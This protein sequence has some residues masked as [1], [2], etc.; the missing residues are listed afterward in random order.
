M[1]RVLKVLDEILYKYEGIPPQGFDEGGLATPKRGLVDEPGSYAGKEGYGSG[2]LPPTQEARKKFKGKK[3]I[4]VPDPSYSDGRRRVMT[5][6]YKAFVEKLQAKPNPAEIRIK[7][8]YKIAKSKLPKGTFPSVEQI[9]EAVPGVK[10]SLDT[11]YSY[12]EKNKLK[13]S[14]P[15]GGT[16][17]SIIEAYEKVSDSGDRLITKNITNK[18]PKNIKTKWKTPELLK[19]YVGEILNQY[20]LPFEKSDLMHT[21]RSRTKAGK[22]TTAQA[23]IENIVDSDTLAKLKADIKKY[24]SGTI[25]G[26][27]QTMKISD[28]K[29]YFPEGTSDVVVSRQVNRLGNEMGLKF[30]KISKPEELEARK[31]KEQ[32][33]KVGDPKGITKKMKGTKE[34]PLHHMRAK[35]FVIEGQ[36]K[37]ISPSLDDL[38]YIDVVTNS[39]RLQNFERVRNNLANELLELKETKPE[40]WERRVKEINALAR[41][42]SNNIP[43][44]LRGLLYFETLDEAGNLKPIGGNPY[45]ALGKRQPGANIPFDSKK[46]KTSPADILSKMGCPDLAAGGRVGFQEGTT[47]FRKGVD[48]VNS[49]KIAKGTEAEN[50]GKFLKASGVTDVSK[51]RALAKWG[52][53]P[54]AAFVAGHSLFGMGMG[55]NLPESLKRASEYILP[56]DQ[57]LSADFDKVKRTLGNDAA[58][59]FKSAQIYKKNLDKLD[60]LKQSKDNALA[61]SGEGDFDYMTAGMTEEDINKYYDKHIKEQEEKIRMSSVSADDLIR[62]ERIGDEAYDISKADPSGMFED[63][64]L[65]KKFGIKGPNIGK[66]IQDMQVWGKENPPVEDESGLNIDLTPITKT[67]EQLN[68]NLL[69]NLRQDLSVTPQHLLEIV[70]RAVDEQGL[71]LAEA[72]KMYENLYRYYGGLHQSSLSD[73]ASVFGGE[74]VYGAQGRPAD[75]LLPPG[76]SFSKQLQTGSFAGGGIAGIRR[77]HAIPP[78]SGPM[79]QGGGLSSMFNRV[80][81]W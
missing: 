16:I 80:R 9:R 57:T 24:K 25:V 46:L 17:A 79:P 62:G 49:G 44:N 78:K 47:C 76:A 58:N 50:F 1:S 51:L 11:V 31:L 73:L 2:T 5:P 8:G 55:D 32:I 14:Q 68:V 23:K 41:R 63:T 70:D 56:G 77:P 53:I 34:M 48:K 75:K 66:A 21:T 52:I 36:I 26:P 39:E 81:K 61:L 20:D 67:Q 64:W 40:G 38:T 27:Q 45:K 28:F 71:P 29:K 43:K 35:G 18:L 13:L 59:L 54:E 37:A 33:K 7:E 15:R 72:Q 3:F 30:K 60:S 69:P 22:T 6:E 4:S 12:T 42:E 65:D 10:P 19:S 74:Q